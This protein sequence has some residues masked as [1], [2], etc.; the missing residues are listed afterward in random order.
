MHE[1]PIIQS[2]VKTVLTASE[3]NHASKV[4]SVDLTIGEMRDLIEDLV[5]NY[6][7][8]CTKNTIAS[9]AVLNIKRLPLILRCKECG[10]TEEL[11]KSE[12][13]NRAKVVCADCSGTKLSMVQGQEFII[14]NIGV[15]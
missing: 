10:N 6:F 7:T 5:Q 8:Y 9:E 2:L 1:L 4:V 12:F 15:I 3:A 14:E 13:L 11:T